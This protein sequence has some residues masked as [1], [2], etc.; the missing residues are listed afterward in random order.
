M[1]SPKQIAKEIMKE[2]TEEELEKLSEAKFDINKPNYTDEWYYMRKRFE[3]IFN[4]FLVDEKERDEK[5]SKV[6]DDL[7]LLKKEK[8]IDPS[9]TF[10]E[11][12]RKEF[13]KDAK[14]FRQHEE[15]R[16]KKY[17][18][19]YNDDNPEVERIGPNVF[20]IK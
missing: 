19:S 1:A 12:M 7:K 13:K 2:L 3:S 18:D 16:K 11:R 17:P 8:L 6:I 9:E 20:K 5:T 10:E 15:E 14:I 4:H